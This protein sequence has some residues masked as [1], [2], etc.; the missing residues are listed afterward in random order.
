VVER[1][2][3]VDVAL[4]V[5]GEAVSVLPG[6]VADVHVA[7]AV[8]DVDERV[9]GNWVALVLQIEDPTLPCR[10]RVDPGLVEVLSTRA[11]L[12]REA[13][14][15]ALEIRTTFFGSA[16]RAQKLNSEPSEHWQSPPGTIRSHP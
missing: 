15:A 7:R 4:V 16:S 8:R 1:G 9:A 6:G 3:A 12:R 11:G 5:D 2:G 14:A 10:A 13:S